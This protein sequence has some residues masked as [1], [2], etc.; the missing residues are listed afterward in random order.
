MADPI[1]DLPLTDADRVLLRRHLGYPIYG[2]PEAGHQGWHYITQYGAMEWRCSH[3][4]ALERAEVRRQ[5]AI[6]E[7]LDAA[8]LDAADN[9]DTDQAAVWVRNK[10]E[11]RDRERLLAS[12]RRDLAAFLG[13]PVGPGASGAGGGCRVIV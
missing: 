4:V 11:L 8:V 10:R 2:S 3:L 6:L 1:S 12:R 5:L 9:L 13:V 7:R